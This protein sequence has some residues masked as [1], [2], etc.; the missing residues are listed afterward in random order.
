M[1]HFKGHIL[2]ETP[3][4]RILRSRGA[5]LLASIID[6]NCDVNIFPEGMRASFNLLYWIIH[7]ICSD[8]CLR[9]GG[10]LLQPRPKLDF[11]G[12]LFNDSIFALPWGSSSS[13]F[14]LFYRWC[15]HLR[16]IMTGSIAYSSSCI[17][18]LHNVIASLSS[19]PIFQEFG[20]RGVVICLLDNIECHCDRHSLIWCTLST[21]SIA[22]L[23]IW[24]GIK[25]T[26][27]VVLASM[28]AVISAHFFF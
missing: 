5:L 3:S 17:V 13:F 23:L 10:V 9:T 18:T 19:Q 2:Y 26:A 8:S 27:S 24:V 22:Y 6:A 15:W 7:D 1:S 16:C 25:L 14:R 20:S 11:V 28:R 21:L 12:V 4:R